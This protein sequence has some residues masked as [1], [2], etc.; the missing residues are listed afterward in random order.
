MI[1]GLLTDAL[2]MLLYGGSQEKY[3]KIHGEL[4]QYGFQHSP[5]ILQTG[6]LI[7]STGEFSVS[8]ERECQYFLSHQ[9]GSL[10]GLLLTWVLSDYRS[11]SILIHND[12]IK[13]VYKGKKN[14][15]GR[16]A[17]LISTAEKDYYI[18]KR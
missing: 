6:R 16:T 15:H 8:A 11:E 10:D 1:K 18:I 4:V 17:Y 2:E 14:F 7:Q 5:V 12:Q 13:K 9:A 3:E